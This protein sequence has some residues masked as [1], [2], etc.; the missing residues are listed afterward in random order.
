M[1]P[2]QETDHH[3]R[4]RHD[5]DNGAKTHSDRIPQPPPPQSGML[6]VYSRISPGPVRRMLSDDLVY[7]CILA[8]SFHFHLPIYLDS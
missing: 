5:D 3:K 2:I 7:L 1:A 6:C 8:F 4:K